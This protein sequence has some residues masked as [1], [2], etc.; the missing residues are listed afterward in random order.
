[1]GQYGQAYTL[2]LLYRIAA[3]WAR[4]HPDAPEMTINRISLPFG[5]P[6]R[7]SASHQTGFDVDIRPMRN[8]GEYEGVTWNNLRY[9]Q[10]LT[11]DLINTIR[12]VAGA[13]HVQYIFF[14]DPDLG[15][16]RLVTPDKP[17]SRNPHAHDN[18]LHVRFRP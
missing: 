8:D 12:R 16:E 17:D 9:D 13:S 11:R 10:D 3:E 7:P 6:F 4:T 5:G 18:H 2:D 1:M 15:N 14:N